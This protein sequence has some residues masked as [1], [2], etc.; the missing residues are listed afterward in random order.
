MN[1]EDL[2]SKQ[3]VPA[4]DPPQQE[5][6]APAKESVK[7]AKPKESHEKMI[8]VKESE[9]NKLKQELSDSRD[10]YL[11]L[12]AEF[13]NV[14]KRLERE[15]A[16]FVKYANEGLLQQFLFAVDDLERTIDA[17]KAN[18][19]DYMAFLKGIEMVMTQIYD[20]LR[21]NNVKVIETKGKK[22]DP[23]CH[24][25][26]MVMESAEQEEGTILEEFQKGYMFGDK[27]I[28]TA[29]VKVATAKSTKE[30]DKTE[31]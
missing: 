7:D 26:L 9:Y 1:K 12:Q 22:F 30:P 19:Q 5:T 29:K 18:H 14:R 13:D 8:S 3:D 15:K 6:E 24:E 28:R 10:R 17:A 31:N 2:K 16:E 20:M 4:Q 21:K 27:I 11:R 25:A 23:H